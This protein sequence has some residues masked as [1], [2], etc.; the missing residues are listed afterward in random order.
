LTTK[1]SELEKIAALSDEML[2]VQL[3]RAQANRDRWIERVDMLQFEAQK[4]MRANEGTT[5]EMKGSERMR[6]RTTIDWDDSRFPELR[7]YMSKEQWAEVWADE[8]EK[9]VVVKGKM[10]TRKL[11]QIAKDVGG[12]LKEAVESMQRRV[13]GRVDIEDRRAG[14]RRTRG[15]G[16][17]INR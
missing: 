12:D 16:R 15:N 10:D 9:K 7:E 4:R 2:G 8:H 13:Y 14:G 3:K 1:Q 5:L 6:S 11:L 17:T